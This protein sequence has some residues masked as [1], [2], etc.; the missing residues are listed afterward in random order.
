MLYDYILQNFTGNDELRP[1]MHNPD[2]QNGYV[3][4]A[5]GCIVLKVPTKLCEKKYKTENPPNYESV[6]PK[7]IMSSAYQ[8]TISTI[9]LLEVVTKMKIKAKRSTILCE[10]CEAKGYK[11]CECCG[12]ENECRE[13]KGTGEV[14]DPN[15]FMIKE[16]RTENDDES[17]RRYVSIAGCKISPIYVEKIL[18]TML[19]CNVKTANFWNSNDKMLIKIGELIVLVMLYK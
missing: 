14:D 11:E 5:D 1:S 10:E 13:C 16:V 17:M 3:Y 4:A 9:E 19:A 18:F 7:K 12:H 2:T 8:R 6:F 15:G